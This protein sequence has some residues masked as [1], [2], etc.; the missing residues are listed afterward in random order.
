MDVFKIIGALGIILISIAI[1]VKKRTTRNILYICGGVCLEI[2]S[3][4]I[5]DAV[6]II[7]QIIFLGVAVFDLFHHLKDKE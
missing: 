1:L 6:F 5:K 7:L 3:I 2:Y 4:Y